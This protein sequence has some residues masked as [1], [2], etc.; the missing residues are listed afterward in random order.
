[1]RP[2]NGV[3]HR[4]GRPVRT[5]GLTPPIKLD[6]HGQPRPTRDARGASNLILSSDYGTPSKRKAELRV[7]SSDVD[8]AR[9]YVGGHKVDCFIRATHRR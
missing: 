1:M 8:E 2:D 7:T 3:S 9:N 5:L 4:N 6:E